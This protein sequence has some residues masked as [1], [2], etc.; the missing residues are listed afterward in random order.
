MGEK[1]TFEKWIR[2]GYR[3]VIVICAVAVIVA[4]IALYFGGPVEETEVD[5]TAAKDQGVV[6]AGIDLQTGFVKDKG[7]TEVIAHCTS[8]HSAQLVTQNRMTKEGWLSTI[9][10]MQ[11]SQNLWDLG[12]NEE[13]ILDYLAKNYAPEN[14]GRREPLADIEWYALKD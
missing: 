13:I 2:K 5:A 11:E 8:C 14:K 3:T 9:R 7:M 4:I 12:E 6:E 10:W 1:G